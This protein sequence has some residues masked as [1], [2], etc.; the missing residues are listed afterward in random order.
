LYE[1]R[2]SFEVTNDT[3]APIVVSSVDAGIIGDAGT[4]LTGTP[5]SDPLAPGESVSVDATTVV[6]TFGMEPT[7]DAG[8]VNVYALWSDEDHVACDAPPSSGA[9]G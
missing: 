5:S 2:V 7:P 6:E 4:R 3:S 1:L 9:P 8:S